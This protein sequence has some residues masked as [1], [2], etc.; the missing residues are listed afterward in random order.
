M[1]ID[2][3]TYGNSPA[4]VKLTKILEEVDNERIR[5]R[6]GNHYCHFCKGILEIATLDREVREELFS[7]W[8]SKYR[9]L[10]LEEADLPEKVASFLF[11]IMKAKINDIKKGLKINEEIRR[12]THGEICT[13]QA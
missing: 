7:L 1:Q 9:K 10:I 4:A 6:V 2:P 12:S 13:D 11:N 8:R 3:Y 5:Q